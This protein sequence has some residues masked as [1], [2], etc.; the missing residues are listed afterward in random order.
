MRHAKSDWDADYE[1]DHER[2]LNGRGIKTAR[3]VGE[4]LA[5]KGLIPE[6]VISSTALRA[7]LTAELAIEA[8]GWDATLI[9]EPELY[10]TG[11]EAAMT[12]AGRA[13]EVERLMLVG[14]Q[15]AWSMLVHGLTG[16]VTEMKT[17]TVAV[18]ELPGDDWTEVAPN[19]GTLAEVIRPRD[20]L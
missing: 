12:V 13:P 7:R 1:Q 8:G 9:L 19:R 15:P 3:V 5:E 11:P 20:H 14:H 18:V 4:V 16:Q 2:P 17:A 10:G 6:L